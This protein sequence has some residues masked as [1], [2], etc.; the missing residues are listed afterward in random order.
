M[1]RRELLKAVG[2]S[3]AALAAPRIGRAERS[4]KLVFAPA[5]EL[6][7][8]DLVELILRKWNGLLQALHLRPAMQE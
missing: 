8:L 4:N 6:S 2:A 7:V 5:A 1:R 3:L